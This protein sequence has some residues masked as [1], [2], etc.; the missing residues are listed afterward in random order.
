MNIIFLI[1][2]LEGGGAE[3]A[4]LNIASSL[5]GDHQVWVVPIFASE[6]CPGYPF[7]GRVRII[8]L[9]IPNRHRL[10]SKIAMYV[11]E[12]RSIRKLKKLLKPD[13][14]ISFLETANIL[15]VLTNCGEKNIIS[16]RNHYSTFL[17]KER[18]HL[19]KIKMIIANR[20]ADKIVAVSEDCRRDL[21]ANFKA[22]E[23]K[24]C[25]IYN[26]Y[27]PEPA[28]NTGFSEQKK[29]F[30]SDPSLKIVS[31]GHFCPRKAQQHL[32]RAFAAASS[33]CPNVNLYLFGKR[34][35]EAYLRRVIAANGLPNR[36]FLEPFDPDSFWYLKRSAL[37]V[38]TSLNEG[39]SNVL[40]ESFACG[41]PIVSADCHS[42]PRELLAPD[43]DCSEKT[44]SIEYAE[45]GVLIP[46]FS[47]KQ[48]IDEPLEPA[49]VFL[50]EAIRKLINDPCL[51]EEYSRREKEKA[52][53][54]APGKILNQWYAIIKEVC[55]QTD[56]F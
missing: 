34:E 47:G 32:I 2:S 7:D 46:E 23:E 29:R 22:P 52:G 42:G 15:N 39:F 18:Y 20:R 16:V 6:N 45:Y 10:N 53:D 48:L 14:C 26:F 30:L 41:L 38:C 31:M 4:C 33:D 54:Y 37:Y 50:A 9:N 51:R 17:E 43:T 49:E 55:P 25:T 35:T 24:T 5:C 13:I 28:E 3:R 12:L 19:K 1:D 8:S 44:S 21:V 11:K 56:L 40:L 36:V 27:R